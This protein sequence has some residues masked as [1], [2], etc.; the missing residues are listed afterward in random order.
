MRP[1]RLTARGIVVQKIYLSQSC[2]VPAY[3]IFDYKNKERKKR[4]AWKAALSD[5]ERGVHAARIFLIRS[6]VSKRLSALIFLLRLFIK[7]KMKAR[8]AR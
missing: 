2:I 6:F 5:E 7:K 3:K 1:S 8:L 4:R